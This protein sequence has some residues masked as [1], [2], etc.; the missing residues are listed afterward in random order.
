MEEFP[1]NSK[2]NPK[3]V[4]K[5]I[6]PVIASTPIKRKTSLGKRFK[7]T[8][9]SGTDSR[10]VLEYVFVD[11]FVPAIK[12]LFVDASTQAVER[13]IFGES[14]RGARSG[15]RY[16]GG[17]SGGTSSAQTRTRYDGY[18]GSAPNAWRPPGQG[19]QPREMSARAR[20]QH[21]FGEIVLDNRGEADVVLERLSD[22]L[23]QYGMTSVSDLYQLVGITPVFT[24]E[25][26]GWTDLKSARI[27]PVRGSQFLL[28]L[29][30]PVELK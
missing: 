26:W 28:D 6:T 8:F 21:D 20:S 5:N 13:A 19:N 10:S 18:S 4:E 14:R 15:Y 27:V 9:L 12:D 2:S 22:I 30:R 24:D 1:S 7:E 16:G 29:P 11:I 25:R 23:E 17:Y 3:A